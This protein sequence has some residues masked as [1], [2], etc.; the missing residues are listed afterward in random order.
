[1][2]RCACGAQLRS[3]SDSPVQKYVTL[4]SQA[5]ISRSVL[6][7]TRRPDFVFNVPSR[8]EQI[9]RLSLSLPASHARHWP[10]G[11]ASLFWRPVDMGFILL[12]VGHFSQVARVHSVWRLGDAVQK[13]STY[14]PLRSRKVVMTLRI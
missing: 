8:W 9:C 2:H 11:R 4:I 12:P 3:R 7:D 5:K 6:G 14:A 10:I 1:V 13:I